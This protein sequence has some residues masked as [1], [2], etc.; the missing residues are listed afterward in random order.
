MFSMP[1]R[2]DVLSASDPGIPYVT[3][4]GKSVFVTNSNRLSVTEV[5]NKIEADLLAGLPLLNDAAYGVPKYHF[6]VAAAN[7]F[8]ARFYLFKRNYPKVIEYATA[9]LGPAPSQIMRNWNYDPATFDALANWQINAESP[10]NLMLIAT[11]STFMRYLSGRNGIRY[12]CNRE[13]AH[14]TIFGE[15]P[16]WPTD[17]T[18]YNCH[19]C[20]SGKLYI[21][22]EQDYGI[23]SPVSPE[24]FEYSDKVAGIGFAHIVRNEFTAEETLLCRSEAY[25]HL[26][27]LDEALSDL[28]VWDNA[29]KNLPFIVKFDTLTYKTIHRFYSNA[30]YNYIAKPLNMDK[31]DPQWNTIQIDSQRVMLQCALHFRR[32][33]TV[34]Q[35]FRWFDIKRYGIEITHEIGLGRVETLTWDDPRR[36]LQLPLEVIATGLDP[37]QRERLPV[38]SASYTPLKAEAYLKK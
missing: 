35:G 37:N 32:I 13:A 7:A 31:I 18:K 17:T 23:W 5:Y 27:Q 9:T 24:L 8:A 14:A 21:N 26:N 36:A 34:F 4:V 33:E 1:Y 15:G 30:K 16:S 11:Y 22:G 10:N 38:S 6:N 20:Y 2:N 19:P 29:R 12:A 25:I 3:E 28:Q